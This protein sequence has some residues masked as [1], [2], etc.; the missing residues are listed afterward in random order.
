MNSSHVVVSKKLVAS[1]CCWFYF[2]WLT[3]CWKSGCAGGESAHCP[4]LE[5]TGSAPL[6]KPA[7]LQTP[8]PVC[9]S[10][11]LILTALCC[12]KVDWIFGRL[13]SVLR[14]ESF[15]NRWCYMLQ[16]E[17][18]TASVSGTYGCFIIGLNCCIQRLPRAHRTSPNTPE[19]MTIE[20][21]SANQVC[22]WGKWSSGH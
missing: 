22:T 13:S 4:L 12:R 7:V 19:R 3:V 18:L 11:W 10:A 17:V 1:L 6:S 8:P 16:N 21:K 5:M 20:D 15:R 2:H 14:L 9:F